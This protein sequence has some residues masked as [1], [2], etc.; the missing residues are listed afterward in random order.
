MNL[1]FFGVLPPDTIDG[2]S[3]SN[4]INLKILNK[5]FTIDIVEEKNTF[6]HHDR[7]SLFKLKLFILSIIAIINHA[8]KIRYKGF[9]LVFSLSTFGSLKTLLAVFFFRIFNRG[10]VI[11]HIHRGDFFYDF[12]KK[13]INRII[14]KIIF[15]MTSVV[16]VLS[17]NQRKEFQKIFNL[18]IAVLHNTVDT[19]GNYLKKEISDNNF[20]YISNYLVDKGI[21]DLLYVFRKLT[22]VYPSLKLT[23]YGSFSNKKLMDI[24]KSYSSLNIEIND[25]ITGKNK[26]DQISKAD[27]L[28]FPSRNEGQPLILLEAMAVG[29]PVITTKVG[30]IPEILGDDYPFLSNP[31]DLVSLE[32]VIINFIK[33]NNKS[34]I[35]KELKEKFDRHYSLAIHEDRLLQIFKYCSLKEYEKCKM[36]V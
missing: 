25:A 20:L 14:T 29:T 5:V 21:L 36:N 16:I 32:S 35:S 2:I 22:S 31:G 30:L 4:Q 9:Y 24:I 23:T 13:R 6:K 28:I 19:E 1:L 7:L 3:I 8:L 12:Y 34:D 10:K 15:S 27:C 17:E 26:F 33:S 18:K 11:L